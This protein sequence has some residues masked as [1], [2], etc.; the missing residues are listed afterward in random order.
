MIFQISC[1]M[2]IQREKSLDSAASSKPSQSRQRPFFSLLN[3][4]LW[5]LAVPPLCYHLRRSDSVPLLCCWK[6]GNKS[7]M[8]K[9]FNFGLN[10]RVGCCPSK[11]KRRRLTQRALR[12]LGWIMALI[13]RPCLVWL[14]WDVSALVWTLTGS[15]RRQ[16]RPGR[17][18]LSAFPLPATR[19]A[20]STH[21]LLLVKKK[22]LP[23]LFICGS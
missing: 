18:H 5:N 12:L 17:S 11:Q 14:F 10:E 13:M 21:K 16:S 20:L 19:P 4:F 3:D 8:F 6:K 7:S 22:S 23:P 9:E 2:F 15:V 1:N